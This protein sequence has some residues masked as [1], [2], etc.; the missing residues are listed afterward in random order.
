M[1]SLGK[2]ISEGDEELKCH[3]GD[4]LYQEHDQVTLFESLDDERKE[5]SYP[6]TNL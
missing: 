1:L 4:H 3:V 5:S 6:W 2:Q